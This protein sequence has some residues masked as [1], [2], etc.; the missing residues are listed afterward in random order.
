[1]IIDGRSGR[2]IRFVPASQWGQAYD[3]MSFQPAP[4]R[5]R[6]VPLVPPTVIKASPQT[7]QTV[8]SVASRAAAPAMAPRPAPVATKPA[9]PPQRSAAVHDAHP[10][11]PAP[12]ATGE[13]RSEPKLASPQAAQAPAAAQLK[14]TQAMPQ[15]Q[16]LE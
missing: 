6:G 14:P 3:R 10:V 9:E 5:E 8:P 7:M 13:A 16:G 2:I 12:Q 4:L 1:L 15:V 11:Q